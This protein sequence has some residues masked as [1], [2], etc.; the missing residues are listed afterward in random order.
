MLSIKKCKEVLNK[1]ENKYTEKE[2]IEI[3]EFLYQM[4]LVI[5]EL[6]SKNYE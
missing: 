4:T 1:K 3:R 2:V 5:E 6:K